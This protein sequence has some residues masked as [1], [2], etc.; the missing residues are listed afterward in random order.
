[1]AV[2]RELRA[3]SLDSKRL[4]AISTISAPDVAVRKIGIGVVDAATEAVDEA[5]EAADEAAMPKI[6]SR[7]EMIAS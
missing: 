2:R 3:I 7:L 4:A 1:M 5:M 6:M